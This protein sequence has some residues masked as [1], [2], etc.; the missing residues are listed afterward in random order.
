MYL[1][2]QRVFV[3]GKWAT[4]NEADWVVQI[5]SACDRLN[6]QSFERE[7]TVMLF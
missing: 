6:F 1:G 5:E 4:Y 7:E 2:I 3:K